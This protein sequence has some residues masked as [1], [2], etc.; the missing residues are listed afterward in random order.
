MTYHSKPRNVT[1]IFH[2]LSICM[3]LNSNSNSS[4]NRAGMFSN[5]EWWVYRMVALT[6]GLLYIFTWSNNSVLAADSSICACTK[7]MKCGGGCT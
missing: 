5:S 6:S 7:K 1:Y 4:V 2:G 3:D